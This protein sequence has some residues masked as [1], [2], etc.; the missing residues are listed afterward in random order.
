M[1]LLADSFSTNEVVNF[2]Q[3]SFEELADP[4]KAGPMAK[5]MKTEMPFYGIQK[6]ERIP[7]N[8]ELRKQFRPKNRR[9]YHSIVRA[10]WKLPHREEK[11]TAI[12]YARQSEELVTFESLPLYELMIR[13]GGW[14]DLVDEIAIHLV[15]RILYKDRTRMKPVL[16]RWILDDDLWIRRSAIIS[17]VL[18]KSATDEEQ[19]FR[20]CLKQ[21]GQQDFFIRKAIGWA[22]RDY[23]KSNQK[24]VSSFLKKNQEKLSNLSY[25]EAA[26][27]LPELD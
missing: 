22:L 20:Y 24:S 25:R 17:Q 23:S 19:L 13:Q 18:H 4:V 27:Y 21:A 11:Y 3:S 6:T 16:D 15:G 1:I 12:E 9:Q 5:Y 8:R 2:V 14:W 26:K 10:L 7:V